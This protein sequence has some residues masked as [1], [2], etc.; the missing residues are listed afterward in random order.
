MDTANDKVKGV[1]GQILTVLVHHL[2]DHAQFCPDLDVQLRVFS[3]VGGKA[4][5]VGILVKD[6]ELSLWVRK[7]VQVVSNSYRA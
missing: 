4:G 2:G 1:L 3:P 7:G 5:K 6:K